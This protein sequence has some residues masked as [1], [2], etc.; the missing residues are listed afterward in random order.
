MFTRIYNGLFRGSQDFVPE[1]DENIRL[2]MQLNVVRLTGTISEIDENVMINNVDDI[3]IGLKKTRITDVQV[4]IQAEVQELHKIIS[5]KLY[6]YQKAI[7]FDKTPYIKSL[8]PDRKYW[9][10]T[11]F[12]T[13]KEKNFYNDIYTL[14]IDEAVLFLDG[15]NELTDKI[16]GIYSELDYHY[17]HQSSYDRN[18]LEKWRFKMNKDGI[19]EHKCEKMT[20]QRILG[21]L[22]TYQDG[23]INDNGHT[24]NWGLYNSSFYNLVMFRVLSKIISNL[25]I[26]LSM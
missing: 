9:F 17:Q 12:H 6:S 1:L 10:K 23:L 19:I 21:S 2:N 20:L 11:G 16:L 5:R 8:K 26:W 4:D 3:K 24:R 14:W 22:I 18:E 13:K 25:D 15:K 7:S